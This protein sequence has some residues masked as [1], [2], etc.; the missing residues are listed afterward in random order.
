[1]KYTIFIDG[2]EGTTG[3]QIR[4]RILKRS[5]IELLHID[6]KKRKDANERKK[7]INAA[8]FVFL[9]LPDDAAREAVSFC[10]NPHTRI[11]DSSTAH[12]VA[13]GWAY[14]F[15]ELSESHRTNIANSKRVAVPGC[16]ASGFA[17]IVFP[18][19]Q[20]QI[21]PRDYPL[22]CH[23]VSGFSGAGKKGIHQYETWR[24]ENS[25]TKNCAN[26]NQTS[27]SQSFSN[28]LASPRMYALTQMHKHLAEMK[29]VSNLAYE[30]IFS[31][32]ICN[33]FSGMSVTVSLHTRL[34][35]KTCSLQN[36]HEIFSAHYAN[37]HFI[38]VADVQ[39]ANILNTPF[40]SA[41]ALSGT[42]QMQIFICGNSDRITL[43]SRF[44][45]LGKGASGAAMQCMNIMMGINE[46]TSLE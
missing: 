31:P 19:V 22:V 44:D 13:N 37:A 24:N 30:P 26:T 36:I 43:T 16:Y 1:M 6:D 2:E 29:S 42:N 10:E 32:Y 21:I 15:P 20:N 28:S 25:Q 7:C 46:A 12:R 38:H 41:D 34:L 11:L 27:Q 35:S 9:C 17:A 33:F 3:L 8:D 40:I 5:D 39:G 18:L 23:A 45:N 4:E 14:G